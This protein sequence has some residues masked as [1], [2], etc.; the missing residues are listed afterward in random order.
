LSSI[1]KL[2]PTSDIQTIQ[3]S[4]TEEIN[5]KFLNKFIT[6]T[7]VT[8]KIE[9][10][11][12][13]FI[14]YNFI[15]H[16]KRYD[17]YVVYNDSN[18]FNISPNIV[19]AFYKTND[20]VSIDLFIL[21]DTFIVF[22]NKQLYCFKCITYSNE[23]DIKNYICTTYKIDIDNIV[24]INDTKFQELQLAYEKIPIVKRYNPF[25]KL[26]EKK[27]FLFFIIYVAISTFIMLI[28]LYNSFINSSSLVQS[29][30][31]KKITQQY[32][33]LK[34]KQTNQKIKYDTKIMPKIIELFRYIKLENLTIQKLTY[35]HNQIT[36]A[37]LHQNKNK[38]LNF[39]TIYNGKVNVH[40]VSLLENLSLY[41]MEIDIEF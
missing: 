9:I 17:I 7:L 35:T 28:F 38:L 33:K 34:Q 26:K 13:T 36:L 3:I 16:K 39:L 23:E 21:K 11:S 25:K 14:W 41:S 5:L 27:I 22:K 8:N 18:Y 32:Q 37:L 10:T 20:I 24:Y 30:Q 2:I 1:S 29:K 40:K 12:E 31:L 19:S 4:V 15:K 6:T